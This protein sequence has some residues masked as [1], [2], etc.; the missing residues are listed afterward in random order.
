MADYRVV[1]TSKPGLHCGHDEAKP[2]ALLSQTANGE[3]CVKRYAVF[4]KA[5]AMLIKLRRRK[6]SR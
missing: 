4:A 1:D 3:C 6:V 2:Y 5:V